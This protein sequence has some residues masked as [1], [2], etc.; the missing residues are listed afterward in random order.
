ME[1]KLHVRVVHASRH[2]PVMVLTKHSFLHD[3]NLEIRSPLTG[4]D[5]HLPSDVQSGHILNLDSQVVQV[6]FDD[7][8]K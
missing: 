2:Q 5:L 3:C 6:N 4:I 7:S 1:E 8:G